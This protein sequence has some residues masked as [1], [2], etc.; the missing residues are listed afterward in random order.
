MKILTSTPIS[1]FGG[2]SYVLEEVLKLVLPNLFHAKL[3]SYGGKAKL[4]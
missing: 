3:L 4:S 1:S 2:L